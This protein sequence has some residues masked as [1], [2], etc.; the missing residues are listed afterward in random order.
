LV[1]E[2]VTAAIGCPV[3]SGGVTVWLNVKR[4]L[5][6][7][8]GGGGNLSADTC[9]ALPKLVTTTMLAPT[10]GATV[11]GTKVLDSVV[12]DYFEV[13]KVEYYLTGGSEHNALVGTGGLSRFGWI[14]LWN[15]ATVPNGTYRLQST[16]FDTYGRRGHGV[17]IT[18]TVKN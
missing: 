17:S 18:I 2:D 3:D 7:A 1:F 15:T 12:M 13:T 8:Q 6:G 11:S 10:N 4:R 14:A 5:H 9:E 16:A